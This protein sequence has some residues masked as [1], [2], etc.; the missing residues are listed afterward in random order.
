MAEDFG[1]GVTRTLSALARQFTGVVWQS[2][3]P[4]LDSELN[5]MSQVDFEALRQTVRAQV[6]SGFFLDPARAQDEFQFASNW[7]NHFKLGAPVEDEPHIYA[8]VNGMI[9]PIAGVNAQDLSNIVRLSPPPETSSRTDFVFLEVWRTLVAPNPSEENKPSADTVWMYGNTQYGGTNIDDDLEDPS[10][11][12]ETT[13]RVQIQYRIRVFGDSGALGESAALDVYPDALEDMNITAQ[14]AADEPLSG[15]PFNFTNMRGELGDPSLWRAG[16]GDVSNGLKTLDGYVYAIPICAVFRRNSR[17]YKAIQLGGGAPEHNGGANRNPSA[18]YL[19]DPKDGAV[20]L[21]SVTLASSIDAGGLIE[22]NVSGLFGS[23]LDDPKLFA[24]ANSRFLVIGQGQDVEYLEFSAADASDTVGKLTVVSRG[25][26]GSMARYWPEGTPVALYIGRPD[27]KYSDQITKGDLLDLRRGVNFG[28]WDFSRLLYHNVAALVRGNLRTCFKTNGA[29][30]DSQGPVLE[31]VDYLWADASGGDSAIPLHVDALDGPDKIRTTWSDAAVVQTGVTVVCAPD[32]PLTNGSTTHTWDHEVNWDVGAGFQPT[33]FLNHTDQPLEWFNGSV[34]FLHIG[35]ETGADGARTTFRSPTE[36]SVRFLSPREWWKSG[37]PTVNPD[38]GQQH[39]V[40]IRFTDEKLTNPAP[41]PNLNAQHPGP[42]YPWRAHN[43]EKPFITLGGIAWSGGQIS[44]LVPDTVLSGSLPGLLEVDLG[45][46]FDEAGSFFADHG[47]LLDPANVANP[48]LRGTRTLYGLLTGDGVNLTG[49]SSELYLVLY[50]DNN[51]ADNNGAFRVLGAGTTGPGIWKA[52]SSTQVVVEPLSQ[53][54]AAW[55]PDGTTELTAE[56]RTQFT[57]A[58]DGE[59]STSGKASLCIVLTDIENQEGGADNPWNDANTMDNAIVGSTGSKMV[60]S[61]SLLYH[62]GRGGTSRIADKLHHLAVVDGGSAYLRNQA[63]DLDGEWNGQT[64][65][66]DS[67]R[68]YYPTNAQLWN[69]LP[70]LGWDAPNAPHYGGRVVAQSEQDRECELFLDRGSKT[71]VFRPFQ[72]RTMMLQG[73]EFDTEVTALMTETYTNG[74]IRDG[75]GIFDTNRTLGFPVPP[76]YMP[77]FGRQDI[78]FHVRT[79]GSDHFLSG[80]NHLFVDGTD[81]SHETFCIIGGEDNQ[82]DPGDNQV[83]PMLFQT[84]VTSLSYCERGDITDTTHPV[85]QARLTSL[86]EVISSD[87]GHGLSGIELPPNHGIA[88]LYG[89]Y[90]RQDYISKA[91]GDSPGGHKDD[92]VTLIED[93]PTNLLLTNAMKQTLFIRQGGGADMTGN[94]HDHTYVIPT[95]VIAHENNPNFNPAA[96]DFEDYA[97]VVECEVFG[98][99]TGFI[100]HNNY[101]LARK[102]SGTGLAVRA[103]GDGSPELEDVEMC[104]PCAAVSNDAAYLS[105][106]RTPYQ[107]DPF[108]TREGDSRDVTDYQHRLGQVPTAD[109]EKLNDIINQF[110]EDGNHVEMINERAFEILASVD[111]YTTLGTGKLGGSLYP[112]TVYDVGLIAPTPRQSTRLPQEEDVDWSRGWNVVTRAFTEGQVTNT[113]RAS[114]VI[115]VISDEAPVPGALYIDITTLDGTKVALEGPDGPSISPDWE[116]QADPDNIRSVREMTAMSI[117]RAINNEPRLARTCRALYRGGDTVELIAVETGAAGNGVSVSIRTYDTP[118]QADPTE[119]L[120]LETP[121]DNTKVVSF[122][123]VTFTYFRGGK[124]Y[125]V[126]AGAGS[127]QL[128]LTGMIEQLPLGILLQDS[129]FLC[130]NPLGDQATAFK[131][132]PAGIRPVQTVLPLTERG[133]EYTR[134][135]GAPGEIIAMSDGSIRRY[136]AYEGPGTGTDSGT[137]RFRIYRGGGSCFMLSGDE[138]GGPIDWVSESLPASLLPVLKGGALACKALLVRNFYEEAYSVGE[139]GR[140]R[141]DGDEIQMVIMTH[142]I[143]GNGNTVEDGV[144]ISG[145]ISPTGFGEGYAAADRYRIEGRPML[146]GRRRDKPDPSIAPA[147][148]PG[149]EEK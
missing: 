112:G 119:Y 58:E 17:P 138:P 21:S 104:I 54:W 45:I 121:Q 47:D 77:R 84:G 28:D 142:G 147:P 116:M 148:Y 86:D 20:A 87:L 146:K 69:R 64:S 23:G 127:S 108:M 92:R 49:K 56:I 88:R 59:G 134:F 52:S 122:S 143:F 1:S 26:G 139:T 19:A 4:P 111:F 70:S 79:D 39:P 37:Y 99:A 12:F 72:S 83:T 105:Y 78:P 55:V 51:N 29:G 128:D 117:A 63:S 136:G 115:H 141:S 35:G 18:A 30:G 113:N 103:M 33:G 50:G 124:D 60:I 129:D 96:P 75:A 10:L 126:N 74:L 40:Q 8:V 109:A 81:E 118:G 43:F 93:P 67:E 16:D 90:E 101:V 98:F 73:F 36:R 85:Y 53:D 11:G 57:H 94:P 42:M 41:N 82:G 120:R 15:E 133:S 34:I 106:A 24:S 5:L 46:D 27:G 100:N 65:F 48:M 9:L 76:E 61:T 31:A 14:G 68:H 6:H 135:L 3:K 95:Q 2:G 145:V 89:I 140:K 25:R 66:P 131:T 91:S 80:I 114:A 71:I 110:D 149:P 123:P 144:E 107:G 44:G 102:T 7:S 137:K 132:S 125:P 22:L 38:N 62:P 32:A 130:E 13:E 97:Y